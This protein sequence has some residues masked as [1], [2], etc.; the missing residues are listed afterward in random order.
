MRMHAMHASLTDKIENVEADGLGKE[1]LAS[2]SRSILN[3][4]RQKLIL[5]ALLRGHPAY[6]SLTV[7]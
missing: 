1:R 6:V 3:L 2:Q 4:V 7:V 5:F